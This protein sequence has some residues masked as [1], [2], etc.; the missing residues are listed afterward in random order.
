MGFFGS[1]S[2]P[3][4]HSASSGAK[5]KRR[6]NK[7][8]KP[9]AKQSIEN[10][11]DIDDEDDSDED[12]SDSD[13]NMF[14][15]REAGVAISSA[16][17]SAVEANDLNDPINDIIEEVMQRSNFSRPRV[18]SCVMKMWD[19]NM[20]YDDPE[21]VI[22]NLNMQDDEKDTT[23]ILADSLAQ[24][25]IK[26]AMSE[27]VSAAPIAKAPV[28]ATGPQINTSSAR[29]RP[30]HPATTK[31]V[32]ESTHPSTPAS[33]SSAARSAPNPSSPAAPAATTEVSSVSLS[34]RLETAAGHQ[35]LPVALTALCSWASVAGTQGI[36]D[37]YQGRALEIILKSLLS[38]SI[39]SLGPEIR[40]GLTTL[41]H[42]ILHLPPS[43]SGSAAISSIVT[44]L[45]AILLQV[46]S[47]RPLAIST[48]G[49]SFLTE[50]LAHRIGMSIRKLSAV[51]S[52]I[53][54]GGSVQGT[55]AQLDAA[56]TDTTAALDSHAEECRTE[57][58]KQSAN[59][60]LKSAFIHRELLH[61]RLQL[62]LQAAEALREAALRPR[63]VMT[64]PPLGGTR[65][66]DESLQMALYAEVGESK[67]SIETKKSQAQLTRTHVDRVVQ[68]H[69]NTM[70][71]LRHDMKSCVTNLGELQ[72]RHDELTSQLQRIER[73][74][75]MASAKRTTLQTRL[76]EE[77]RRY[78]EHLSSLDGAQ[79]VVMSAL[80]IEDGAKMMLTRVHELETS[81]TGVVTGAQ[82]PVAPPA[83]EYPVRVAAAS[84]ALG[85][86]VISE[87]KC[88]FVLAKRVSMT[89]NR[90]QLLR[91][92]VEEY[93][94]LD[95]QAIGAELEA[96]IQKLTEET[97]EDL[98][99]LSAMREA[100]S[101]AVQRFA[102]CLTVDLAGVG[103][104]A[105]PAVALSKAVSCL[106][107]AGVSIPTELTPFIP[108][109]VTNGSMTGPP[110]GLSAGPVAPG[111]SSSSSSSSSGP[112]PT[113]RTSFQSMQAL[114]QQAQTQDKGGRVPMESKP[115]PAPRTST[116]TSKA[117]PANM[118]GKGKGANTSTS[119]SL[120]QP[121]KGNKPAPLT[122]R[123]VMKPAASTGT[124]SAAPVK[125]SWTGWKV[126][127][128]VV[129]PADLSSV[130]A[131][132]PVDLKGIVSQE[133]VPETAEEVEKPLIPVSDEVKKGD[134]EREDEEEDEEDESNPLERRARKPRKEH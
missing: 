65:E 6:R 50:S 44:S 12:D 77:Q 45:E 100:L 46:Q 57:T 132:E 114:Q 33:V 32:K 48:G 115:P 70:A 84:E 75:S 105:M 15:V 95:M 104:V 64:P 90:L 98:Q 109:E 69:D 29:G 123:S 25:N 47:L 19:A 128:H 28:A 24:L 37:F 71:T 119:K 54:G 59:L 94:A 11:P 125:S 16:D 110:P 96:N 22:E 93:R 107:E 99:T 67:T 89:D 7:K 35:D 43:T 9:S 116:P 27:V 17:V 126:P 106:M 118:K 23:D 102:S 68:E 101:E 83:E 21:S 124:V 80:R 60:D 129:P 131:S 34:S 5:K 49:Y 117:S 58:M 66:D 73:D 85:A 55:I 62:E 81:L 92:E 2:N 14:S 120:N 88:I 127:P 53:Y 26:A 82:R 72:T 133:V 113:S 51:M 40:G 91:R 130:T 42:F 121:V 30:T 8:K 111:L 13:D 76:V 108:R 41:L 87:A 18:H 56:L 97:Q 112:L 134:A 3:A 38:Q 36:K 10:T 31:P 122:A 61:E 74:I 78:D 39:E 86:Y 1:G 103:M 63:A 79:Q 52:T 20:K 4:Q